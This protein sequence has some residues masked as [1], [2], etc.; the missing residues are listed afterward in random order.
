MRIH[1]FA[2]KINKDSKDIIAILQANEIEG[3]KPA[4]S[5]SE[6]EMNMVLEKLQPE[7]KEEK[8][9]EPKKNDNV[10]KENDKKPAE[11]NSN[12]GGQN[13]KKNNN[14]NNSGKRNDNGNNGGR[15]ND[16][17]GRNNNNN[18]NN[19]NRNNGNNNNNRNNNRNNNNNNRNNNGRNNKQNNN[20]KN[21]SRPVSAPQPKKEEEIKVITIPESITIGELADKMKMQASALIKKLFM[22]GMMLSVNQ[23]VDFETAENIALEFDI[24]AEQEEKVD[25]IEELL[26]EDEE[27]EALMVKRPPVVCVMGH[28]DHGKT[29]LLDAIRKTNVISGEAGGI[30]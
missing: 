19:N 16:G 17:N 30:T 9:E 29:S 8:K 13:Q 14:N 4:S 2:K 26:K 22:Q 1:E 12:Q 20:A 28:V 5:I 25:V 18:R 21:S 15:N 23:E 27:D 24:I 6:S 7:K 10:K 11:K 3:K